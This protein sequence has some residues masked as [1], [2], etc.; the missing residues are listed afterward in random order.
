M[1]EYELFA[2]RAKAIAE[3]YKRKPRPGEESEVLPP[4][5][6]HMQLYYEMLRNR[7]LYEDIPTV[8]HLA[9]TGLCRT[10]CEAVAEGIGS[11]SKLNSENRGNLR[12]TSLE[13][14]T[15]IRHLILYP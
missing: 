3:N 15:I 5:Y 6:D 12:S 14:E 2:E 1:A 9:M 10:S 7:D 4:R 11:V 13:A 8:L